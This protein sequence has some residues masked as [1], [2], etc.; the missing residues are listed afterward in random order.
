MS[1]QDE[2][3][4]RAKALLQVVAS[5]A[6]G[7]TSPLGLPD[8]IAQMSWMNFDG[9]N[10]IIDI[11]SWRRIDQGFLRPGDEFS[12]HVQARQYRDLRLPLSA[13]TVRCRL[14]LDP[15]EAT[16][17]VVGDTQRGDSGWHYGVRVI[18]ATVLDEAGA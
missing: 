2:Y 10:R 7:D 3:A 14:T 8:G 6:A 17:V 12:V 1:D 4:S 9:I 18:G 15:A 5:P 16:L 13:A 11:V